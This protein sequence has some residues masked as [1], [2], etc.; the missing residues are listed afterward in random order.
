METKNK[1]IKTLIEYRDNRYGKVGSETRTTFEANATAL[2]VKE[3]SENLS[4][5]R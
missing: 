3:F 4:K 5:R 1:N 2:V